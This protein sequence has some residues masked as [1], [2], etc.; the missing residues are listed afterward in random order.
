VLTAIACFVHGDYDPHPGIAHACGRV[1]APP[2][3]HKIPELKQQIPSVN[4]GPNN[5]KAQNINDQNSL[6]LGILTF[7]F[8]WSLDSGIWNLANKIAS[9]R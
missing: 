3:Q 6:E 1:Q 2:L 8:V 9:S 5:I 7:G 4:S